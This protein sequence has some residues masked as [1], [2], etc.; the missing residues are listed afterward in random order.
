MQSKK[1]KWI[2]RTRRNLARARI[3]E[4]NYVY[5]TPKDIDA[6]VAEFKPDIQAIIDTADARIQ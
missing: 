2:T 3:A 6:C 5:S 1:G 4:G